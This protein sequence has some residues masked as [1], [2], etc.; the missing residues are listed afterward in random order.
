MNIIVTNK[1]KEIID[2]AN[3]DAIKDL[4]GLFNVD[5]LISKLR[6]YF[7]S[8]VILDATSVI[9]FP[10][11]E[12]LE[13]LANGIGADRLVILLPATPEPPREF[14]ER[15]VSLKIY[16]FSNKIDDVIRFINRPNTYNDVKGFVSTN[17]VDFYVDNSIKEDN[18]N[19]GF[20]NTNLE[21]N[22]RQESYTDEELNVDD[23]FDEIDNKK[24]MDISQSNISNIP[25]NTLNNGFNN[26]NINSL[27]NIPT[28][29]INNGTVFLNSN[30][31]NNGINKRIIGIKNI[32]E[33]AGST[34][35]TYLLTKMAINNLH[36]KVLAVEVNKNDF[37]YYQDP[38]MISVVDGQL[39][40]TISNKNY[41]IIF[42]DLNDC[43]NMGICND[44][45]YLVEPSIIKLNKLMAMNRNIFKELAGKKIILNKSLL[46]ES[47]VITFSNEAGM[48]MFYNLKPLNDRLFNDD[49]LK[50]LHLLGIN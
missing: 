26:G 29:G 41:D 16:N 30:V 48:S 38:N 6:N 8:R 13:K 42:I 2:N 39:E 32:T 35:L 5:D 1:Q 25:L 37:S 3:I 44:I 45:I 20:N 19:N 21:L 7:F 22:N 36:K 23:D 15:L 17:N 28:G 24:N 12:V 33:H 18:V 31:S 50:L 4:N 47:D 49:I 27:E 43:Q 34:T 10:T 14:V 46:N 40:N 9:S 11:Q